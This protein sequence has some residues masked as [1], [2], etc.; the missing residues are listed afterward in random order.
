[1][2]AFFFAKKEFHSG[3]TYTKLHTRSPVPL[4]SIQLNSSHGPVDAENPQPRWFVKLHVATQEGEKRRKMDVRYPGRI[5][6]SAVTTCCSHIHCH[7]HIHSYWRQLEN[8][9][10][11]E[12]RNESCPIRFFSVRAQTN[13]WGPVLWKRRCWKHGLFPSFAVL[14]HERL[15]WW[16]HVNWF[17]S[18]FHQQ[19]PSSPATEFVHWKIRWIVINCV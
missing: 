8:V 11:V 4:A 13:N 15:H 9:P 5:I 2:I 7:T 12:W 1:M 18:F 16:R 19:L 6:Y 17:L 14:L 3:H 10:L